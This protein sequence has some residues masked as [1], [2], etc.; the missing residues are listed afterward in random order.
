MGRYWQSRDRDRSVAQ[1]LRVEG[2]PVRVLVREVQT[3][4]STGKRAEGTQGTLAS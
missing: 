4:I 3:P 1:P 2:S